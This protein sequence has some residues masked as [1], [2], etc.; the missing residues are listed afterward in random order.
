ML[1]VYD[2]DDDEITQVNQTTWTPPVTLWLLAVPE[3]E[4]PSQAAR[5]A[6]RSRS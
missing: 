4:E 1:P 3:G 6:E 5:D 2:H